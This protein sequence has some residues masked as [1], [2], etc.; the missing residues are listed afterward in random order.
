MKYHQAGKITH[1][2]RTTGLEKL[3][4]KFIY[5]ISYPTTFEDIDRFEIDNQVSGFF[6]IKV[7]TV[8]LEQSRKP[9]LSSA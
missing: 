1:G 9:R 7:M 2:E 4:D 6:I 3:P 5:K 8:Q